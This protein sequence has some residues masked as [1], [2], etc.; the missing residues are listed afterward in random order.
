M[1]FQESNEREQLIEEDK[2]PFPVTFRAYSRYFNMG[3][4]CCGA[5]S[6]ILLCLLVQVSTK[7]PRSTTYFS[8]YKICYRYGQTCA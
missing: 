3:G 7:W 1:T 5:L 8:R 6:F 2:E 4:G